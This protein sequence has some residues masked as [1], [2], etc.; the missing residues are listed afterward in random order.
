[1][2][3]IQ[4]DVTN[5]EQFLES[6]I[7]EEKMNHASISWKNENAVE[8]LPTQ[9]KKMGTII[10]DIRPGEAE[11]TNRKGKQA[12]LIMPITHVPTIDDV[13]LTL[14]QT[15]KTHG[16]DITGCSFLPDGR[17]I[18]SCYR[19]CLISVLQTNGSLHFTLK[20][21]FRTSQ[22]YYIEESQKLVV[23]NGSNHNCVKIIDMKSRKTEKLIDV[24]SENYGIV[25]KDGKLYCNGHKGGL[26]VVSLDEDSIIQLVNATLS[27]YSSI[28]IWSDKLYVIGNDDSVICC[29]LQG[30]VKWRLELN[31]FL[32]SARGITVNNCG[33]VYV[34]G[35]FSNN[36]V[37]IS[38]DGNK[39]RVLLSEKDGLDH[40]QALCYNQKHNILLVANERKNAFIY[41]VS[42]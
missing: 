20:P 9:I 1:M 39:H 5:N 34:A 29:D 42:K 38:P 37:V 33:Y 23:T 30:A 18:F 35:F 6:L 19:N 21:G 2:K 32:K 28:A 22:I 10:L 13:R 41:D 40:P 27:R 7:K 11:L 26:R 17:M 25:H 3:H 8:I 14:R 31:T 12:Q 15:V 16:N 4:R 36:V 24:G